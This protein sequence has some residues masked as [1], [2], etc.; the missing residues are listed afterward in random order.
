MII[1]PGD[2]Y[3]YGSGNRTGHVQLI[4]AANK[5]VIKLMTCV[6]HKNNQ[7]LI[8]ENLYRSLFEIGTMKLNE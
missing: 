6:T 4:I 1:N 2:I 5:D 7:F 3:V 8:F